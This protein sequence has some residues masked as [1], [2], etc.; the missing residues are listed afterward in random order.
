MSVHKAFVLP[1]LGVDVQGAPYP[2]SFRPY[3]RPALWVS[4]PF[5]K[6]TRGTL[7]RVPRGPCARLPSVVRDCL[8]QMVLPSDLGYVGNLSSILQAKYGRYR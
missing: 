8:G 5:R 6:R 2:C 4:K 7:R 3:P 1:P